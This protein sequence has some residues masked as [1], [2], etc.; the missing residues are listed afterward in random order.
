MAEKKQGDFLAA[1]TPLGGRPIFLPSP[2]ANSGVFST[3][4]HPLVGSASVRYKLG[5]TGSLYARYARGFK[6]SGMTINP[7]PSFSVSPPTYGGET[8]DSYEVGA[9]LRVN[10]A[11]QVNVAVFDQQLKNQQV[12]AF[13]NGGFVTLNAAALSINGVEADAIWRPFERLDITGGATYLDSSYKSFPLGPNVFGSPAGSIQDL[14]GR[15]PRWS[16]KWTVLGAATYRQPVSDK[17]EVAFRLD[18]RY[19]SPVNPV[20][21]LDPILQNGAKFFLN[22]SATLEGPDAPWSIQIWAKNITDEVV[23][24]GGYAAFGAGSSKSVVAYVG[25]PHTYGVTLG[26]K[27]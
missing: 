4:D 2:G 25:D 15:R 27:W 13:I 12:V 8:L 11:L 6:S 14:T 3:S 1:V 19:T 7:V 24:N 5:E 26:W 23:I 17:L 9:K 20:L 10:G 22:A 18:G 21:S 16:P